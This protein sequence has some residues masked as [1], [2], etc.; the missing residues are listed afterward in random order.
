MPRQ[1]RNSGN[2]S[3]Y[4]P[5]MCDL[6]IEMGKMGCFPAEIA[7]RIGVAPRTIHKW[8]DQ[9][10]EFRTACEIAGVACQ[11][12]WERKGRNSLDTPREFNGQVW[13]R[14]MAR[15]PEWR[16]RQEVQVQHSSTAQLLAEIRERNAQ[17]GHKEDAS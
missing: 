1:R 7:A 14:T 16:E 17:L 9:Y 13:A 12:W 8:R 5:Q 15:F 3:D 4:D 11:A 2:L 10:P 6:V